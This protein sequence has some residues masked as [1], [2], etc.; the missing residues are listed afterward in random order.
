MQVAQFEI[1]FMQPVRGLPY[2]A[3]PHPQPWVISLCAQC[4]SNRGA[5]K[6]FNLHHLGWHRGIL[7]TASAVSQWCVVRN[8]NRHTLVIM[9]IGAS[10][11]FRYGEVVARVQSTSLRIKHGPVPGP[12]WRISLPLV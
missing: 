11:V 8:L 12:H 9:A 5:V 4:H 7:K 2:R 1:H 3:N 10:S 6:D